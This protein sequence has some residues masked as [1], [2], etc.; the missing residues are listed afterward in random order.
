MPGREQ[1][2][3]VWNDGTQPYLYMGVANADAKMTGDIFALGAATGISSGAQRYGTGSYGR[4]Q[5][6]DERH[7]EKNEQGPFK[8]PDKGFFHRTSCSDFFSRP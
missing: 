8:R 6:E 3:A 2:G 5:A 4:E 1:A 7:D